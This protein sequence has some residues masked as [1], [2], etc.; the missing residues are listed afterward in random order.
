MTTL[1]RT[2]ALAAAALAAPASRGQDLTVKAPPQSRPVL[3]TNVAV[4][5]VSGPPI[6]S[7]KVLFIDGVIRHVGGMAEPITMVEAVVPETIDGKGKRLYPGLIAPAT[8]IGL[9]EISSVRA[10]RDFAEVGGVTPEV[11]AAVAVNPDSWHFP[12]ARMTGVLTACVFPDGGAIPGRA[13]VV[14]MDGWTW[15]SMAVLDDA[16][17]VVDW[18]AVRPIRAWWMDRSDEEQQKEIRKALDR[19]E[20]A[21]ASAEAYLRARAADASTP[22]SIRLEA[23]RPALEGKRPVFVRCQDLEQIQSAVTWGAKRGLRMV[24]VGGR[25]ALLCAD[26]LKKH[27]VGVIVSGTHRLPRRADAAYDEPFTLPAELEKAGIRWALATP[28]ATS[29]GNDRNLPYQAAT[30]V[31]FGLENAAALRG[32]T[33]GAA[34]LLGV[35]DTLGS[36]EPGKAATIFLAD[37]DPLEI[38]TRIEAA[39]IDGRAIDL[40][41]KQTALAAKYREKYRQL[42]LIN[43]SQ[44]LRNDARQGD[45]PAKADAPAPAHAPGE[46]AAA[47]SSLNR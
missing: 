7:G 4:Y 40:S 11:R 31:A 5:P 20:Q 1:V 8:T 47:P 30:A 14:R 22:T 25:D 27:D 37:G 46:P 26:L 12:V 29:Q 35:S 44:A 18:P 39:W 24:I 17:L 41:N 38:T 28:G 43:G 3:I 21:F 36:I 16:G 6:A 23:M 32:V 10:T 13:S 45:K 42:G 2:I 9:V 15:E 33:L 34:Q 19:I